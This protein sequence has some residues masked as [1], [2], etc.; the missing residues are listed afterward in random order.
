MTR[1]R[2]TVVVSVSLTCAF[3]STACV[4][5][6]DAQA[7]RGRVVVE[8]TAIDTNQ[9]GLGCGGRAIVD[10]FSF[11]VDRVESGAAAT[12]VVRVVALCPTVRAGARYRIV[13]QTEAPR[14]RGTWLGYR[15]QRALPSDSVPTVWA[16]DVR[17]VRAAR[18]ADA[19]TRAITGAG[20]R[21][22]LP[23]VAAECGCVYSCAPGVPQG[24]GR[25]TVTHSA[26]GGAPI[27]ARVRRWCASGQCTDA[28]FGEIPCSVVCMPRPADRTCHFEGDRCVGAPQ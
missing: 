6:V 2:W 22:C 14:R 23:V 25:Y 15:L 8:G 7:R 11:R 12:G 17:A 5:R 16:R 4:P 9:R 3:G 26:W 13:A 28:F 18:H 19:G 21:L 20:G 1:L 24:G 10:W 27:N